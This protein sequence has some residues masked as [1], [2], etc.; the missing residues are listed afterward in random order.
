MD[1]D[2]KWKPKLQKI[3]KIIFLSFKKNNLIFLKFTYLF[4]K[5][6]NNVENLTRVHLFIIL[7]ILQLSQNQKK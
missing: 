7:Y 5:N 3:Q 6:R 4:K 1:V 2:E